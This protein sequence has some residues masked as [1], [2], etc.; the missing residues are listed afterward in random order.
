MHSIALVLCLAFVAVAQ[1]DPEGA[2][3]AVIMPPGETPYANAWTECW[4]RYYIGGGTYSL[5][6]TV[7]SSDIIIWADGGSPDI[8]TMW[9]Y[10]FIGKAIVDETMWYTNWSDHPF[11]YRHL[12]DHELFEMYLYE[13][14][15]P[16]DPW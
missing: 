4:E 8:D 3:T 12:T 9:D 14:S 6:E 5:R 1:A 16:S 2:H 11:E 10:Y 13:Q 7:Q 15:R